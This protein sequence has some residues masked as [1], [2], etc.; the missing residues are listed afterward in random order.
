MANDNQGILRLLKAIKAA[1]Q[2]ETDSEITDRLMA[3]FYLNLLVPGDEI[4]SYQLLPQRAEGGH[5]FVF[6]AQHQITGERVVLKTTALN[7]ELFRDL[8][9]AKKNLREEARI[10][11]RLSD[12]KQIIQSL[13]Y[14]EFKGVSYLFLEELPFSLEEVVQNI[15]RDKKYGPVKSTLAVG[16]CLAQSLEYMAKEGIVHLDIAPPNIRAIETNG[17]Y[18]LK[19]TDFT[20]AY[21]L[22]RFQSH[23]SQPFNFIFRPKFTAPELKDPRNIKVDRYPFHPSLDMYSAGI[24]L[25]QTAVLSFRKSPRDAVTLIYNRTNDSALIGYMQAIGIPP[26]IY[27]L[28]DKMIQPQ[29]EKRI[30]PSEMF[31]HLEATAA[32]YS[33]PT[34]NRIVYSSDLSIKYPQN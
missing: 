12:C 25:A 30:T 16:Y 22:L 29:P 8:T 28:I 2:R 6:H 3:E 19:L 11:N 26:V 9:T 21:D 32:I 31:S 13:G 23:Q 1:T 5:A 20:G 10:L 17:K 4:L 33:L 27:C 34:E 15:S 14:V 18:Q 24:T 7:E